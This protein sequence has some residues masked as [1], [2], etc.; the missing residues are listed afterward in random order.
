MGAV[1]SKIAVACLAGI[2]P[3]KRTRIRHLLGNPGLPHARDAD[4]AI[5]LAA[6]GGGALGVWATRIPAGLEAKAAQ[7]GVPV[8]RIE[9]GFI[10]SVGLGAALHLPA[11]VVLDRSGIHYDPSRPSDLETMLSSRCFD[12][13]ERQRA[14]KLIDNLRSLAVTKYNL[15]G[16]AVALPAGRRITLVIGQVADDASMQLGAAGLSTAELVER[17]RAADPGAYL[18][19]KPHPDVVAG[20]RSGLVEASADLIAAQGDLLS[21]IERADSVHVLSSLAGFEALLRG[22]I[23]HVHGQPFYAGWGLTCDHNPVPRRTRSLELTELVAAALIAYPLYCHPDTGEPIEV[24]ELVGLLGQR[25][26][27]QTRPGMVRRLGG[28][29]ALAIGGLKG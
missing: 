5:R 17:A 2:A 29:A 23:V 24:E 22:K 8:W 27:A 10:R 11:S 16:M 19:Y 7:A 14:N 15:S 13:A 6:D 26:P 1:D 28:R 25:E 3:W 20:L 18:V 21:L 12:D 4:D 9:D